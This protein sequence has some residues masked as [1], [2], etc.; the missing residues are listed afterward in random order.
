MQTN[1]N[2]KDLEWPN[3]LI[4]NIGVWH[5][6]KTELIDSLPEDFI[7]SLEYVLHSL[8]N[9][10][11]VEILRLHYQHQMTYEE[12]GS[13]MNL[14]R[15][16]IGQ[17]I[18]RVREE[19]RSPYWIKF[20]RYGIR[21]ILEQQILHQKEICQQKIEAAVQEALKAD[22]YAREVEEK[23]ERRKALPLEERIRLSELNLD[24]RTQNS[25][26]RGA[27]ETVGDLLRL[28]YKRLE[29]IQGI[30]KVNRKIIIAEVERLGFDCE[31]L[32][33]EPI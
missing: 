33:D 8:P 25:L 26:R 32:K 18:E 31:H 7:G 23:V 13:Q 16:R 19:I 4:A 30:G 3:N 6:T 11:N 29:Q 1:N 27:L 17:M 21:G 28:D 14:S 20:L 22:R 24:T 10:R 12:I 2:Y 5:E 9:Q 15:A